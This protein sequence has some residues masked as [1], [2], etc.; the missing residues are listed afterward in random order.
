M[1]PSI[2]TRLKNKVVAKC[3][4]TSKWTK[5]KVHELKYG[6]QFFLIYSMGK[7]GST[8][9]YTFLK[10]QYPFI[11]VHHVH[12]LS[13]YWLKEKL[14]KLDSFFHNNIKAAASVFKSLAKH[15]DYRLKIITMVRD[16][17]IRE[18]SDIFQNWKGI[19]DVKT[20]DELTVDKLSLYLN[21]H[22][23]DYV[24]NWFDSELKAYL[25][26]DIYSFPFDKE[27]GYSIYKTA[28]ADILCFQL[29]K[30]NACFEEAMK[31]FAGLKVAVTESS[32]RSETKAGKDT[33]KMIIKQYKP[34]AEKIASLY[35]SKYVRHFYSEKDIN[36]F[37]KKWSHDY[38]KLF[39]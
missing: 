3:N 6:K 13:D 11:P 31:E 30:M 12:F 37:V 9:A 27:K 21:G 34:S 36:G 35:N 24:L 32:N 33:Y 14:P 25:G 22:N 4:A 20:V 26:F 2:P 15:P 29:E 5:R 39:K 17:M 23:H 10:K 1:K 18:I 7:V 28:S 19:L 38:C 8:T 16:P